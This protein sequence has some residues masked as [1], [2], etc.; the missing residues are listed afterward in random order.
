MI[1]HINFEYALLEL[2][3]CIVPLDAQN[4]AKPKQP[5]FCFAPLDA[6][7]RT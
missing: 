3:L 4:G 1:F 6:D 5:V 2:A 7:N